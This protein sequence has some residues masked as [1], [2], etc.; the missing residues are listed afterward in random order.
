MIVAPGKNASIQPP[1]QA[2]ATRGFL[3]LNLFTGAPFLTGLRNM[4]AP[5]KELLQPPGR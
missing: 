5:R 1:F 2:F 4:C 3:A